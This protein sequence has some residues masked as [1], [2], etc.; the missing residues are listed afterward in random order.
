MRLTDSKIRTIMQPLMK[1]FTTIQGVGGDDLHRRHIA[2]NERH[3]IMDHRQSSSTLK[4]EFLF[5]TLNL[6]IKIKK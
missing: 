3:E 2:I 1:Y 6:E 5:L 4:R